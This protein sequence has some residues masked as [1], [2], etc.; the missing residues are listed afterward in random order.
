MICSQIIREN[1]FFFLRSSNYN[2]IVQLSYVKI[3]LNISL[4]VINPS[5]S[6]SYNVEDL[7]FHLMRL[8]ST[9]HNNSCRR[10]ASNGL[11][12]TGDLKSENHEV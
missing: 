7:L 10:D 8:R 12:I 6:C 11:N 9:R 5:C 1:M 4:H 3:H 2:V